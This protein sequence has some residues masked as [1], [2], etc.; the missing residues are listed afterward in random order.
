MKVFQNLAKLR[1][2]HFLSATEKKVIFLIT[3]AIALALMCTEGSMSVICFSKW[4]ERMLEVA[5]IL[6]PMLW[7]TRL[8]LKLKQFH[9]QPDKNDD[10]KMS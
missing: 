10:V 5:N 4:W 6:S 8:T 9:L 2:S 1:S 3:A 7:W